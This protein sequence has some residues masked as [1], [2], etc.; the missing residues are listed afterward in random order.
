MVQRASGDLDE[1]TEAWSATAVR[2]AAP[3]DLAAKAAL[4]VM[5]VLV[6]L[7]PTWG[8]LEGK[9]PVG[10]AVAYPMLALVLPVWWHFRGRGRPFPWVADL[11]VTLPGFSDFLGNRLDLYDQ[12]AWFDDWV[13]FMNAGL[14]SGAVLLL[15]GIDGVPRWDLV[16]R[17]VAFGVT[18]SL[19]WELWEFWAFI[20]HSDEM[21]TAYVDTLGD[22]GLAW[23]GALTAAGVVIVARRRGPGPA[24][25]G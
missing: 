24:G 20:T 18:V 6:L 15:T 16:S 8:N 14:L 3:V 23:L 2:L 25:A 10:R 7:D 22:L 19:A 4:L 17:A 9:A 1:D 11:M 12:V 21:P 13:H 5:V